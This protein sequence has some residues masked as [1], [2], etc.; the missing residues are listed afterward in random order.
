MLNIH[1]VLRIKNKHIIIINY[2]YLVKIFFYI[3]FLFY[4]GNL[5]D[6]NLVFN[7]KL[8]FKE[9]KI[10]FAKLFFMFNEEYFFI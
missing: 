4:F 1:F 10:L 9:L 2:L 7:F 5:K 8:I 3:K 6:I